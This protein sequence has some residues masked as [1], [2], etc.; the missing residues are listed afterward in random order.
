MT[1]ASEIYNALGGIAV[2]AGVLVL[3]SLVGLVNLMSRYVR[4]DIGQY[5]FRLTGGWQTFFIKNFNSV[6]YRNTLLVHVEAE[7]LEQVIVHAGPACRRAPEL[8]ASGA[9]QIAFAEVPADA[10][11]V[12]RVKADGKAITLGIP[13]A[14]PLQSRSFHRRMVATT[15]PRTLARYLVR[16]LVGAVSM[17]GVFLFGLHWR[18]EEFWVADDALIG[19]MVLVSV[20]AFWLIAPLEGKSIV[21]GYVGWGDTGRSWRRELASEDAEPDEPHEPPAPRVMAVACADG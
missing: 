18:G 14:S 3:A 6:T 7:A 17:I 9:V 8:L 4:A 5:S 19:A 21:A 16:Y 2:P 1:I 15:L 20:F 13:E 10:S 12:V 11:F